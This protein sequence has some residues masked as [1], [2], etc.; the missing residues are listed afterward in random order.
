[1]I[2]NK[3]TLLIIAGITIFMYRAQKQVRWIIRGLVHIISFLYAKPMTH[4]ELEAFTVNNLQSF[5]SSLII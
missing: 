1:M 4:L 2:L 3:K 5:I